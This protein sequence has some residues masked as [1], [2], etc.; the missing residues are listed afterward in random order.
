VLPIPPELLTMGFGA[1]TGFLFKF[2]AER[3]K[4]REQQF[5][6]MIQS[7]ELAIQEA[8]A[9]S[10]RDGE[11]DVGFVGSSLFQLYSELFLPHLF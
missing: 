9:A 3:A 6:M 4:N 5:K 2:M 10:K 11:G 1:V 8:D 7:R